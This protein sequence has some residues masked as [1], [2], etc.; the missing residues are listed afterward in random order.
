MF[1]QTAEYALRAISLLAEHHPTPLKTSQIAEAT[2]VPHPYLVKVLQ[3]LSRA[4]IVQT[5]RGVGGGVSMAREL[6]EVTMLDVINAVDPIERITRCPIGLA[7][8][9]VHL[10]PMHSRLDAALESIEEV[11]QQTTLAEILAEPQSARSQCKF[12]RVKVKR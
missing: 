8:H 7:A 6:D 9:G 11:F 2:R 1:S 12:P 4:G 3:S 10:C 5:R